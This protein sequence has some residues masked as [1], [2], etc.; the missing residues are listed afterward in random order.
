MNERLFFYSP[1]NFVRSINPQT[2]LKQQQE[3]LSGCEVID[4]AVGQSS[5]KFYI[6]YLDWDS[7]YFG[8]QSYKL[9]FV[10]FDHA[11]F[12]KVSAAVQQFLNQHVAKGAY[13]FIEIPS[14]DT[15]LIQALNANGFKLIETRLT[16]FNHELDRFNFDRH[17]VRAATPEDI[18]TLKQV[19]V[20]MRNDFDRFHADSVF[21]NTLA[22]NYLSTYI[23][24]SING[25]ADCVLVPAE[26]GLPSASFLTAKFLKESWKDYECNISK[27]V[28]SAVS[29]QLNKGWYKKLITEM[30]YFLRDEIGAECI[31]MN[32]QSSNRAV[33]RTWEHLGYRL[34]AVH[35]ILSIN[36]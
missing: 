19:A 10:S 30:T 4:V 33:I 21:D 18:E 12:S 17:L 29:A 25:F 27:M 26:P 35:H 15:L 20:S 1:V 7:A 22:D 2:I 34:G 8:V 28:L 13:L 11:D 14:E 23:E 9:C 36:K 3:E 32:T 24:N 5:H 16:Y 6:K 31:Y